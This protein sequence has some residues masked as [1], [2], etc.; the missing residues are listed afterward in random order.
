MKEKR[1]GKTSGRARTDW[2][3]VRSLSD[4]EVRRAIKVDPD[5]RPTDEAFWKSAR[6]VMPQAKQTIAR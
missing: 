6:V 5:A 1:T 3:R 2:K 4:H